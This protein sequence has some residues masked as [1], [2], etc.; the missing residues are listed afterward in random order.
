MLMGG[1]GDAAHIA[2]YVAIRIRV[3]VIDVLGLVLYAADLIRAVR[4]CTFVPV[5]CT[6]LAPVA[7]C[8]LMGGR[9]D[10]A[11]I[12]AYV[13]VRIRVIVIDVRGGILYAADLIRAVR[14][15]AFL[16]V[17]YRVMNPAA[18]IV[19]MVYGKFPLIILPE[20]F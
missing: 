17:V 20:T 7:V 8:M 10:A 13:A 4:I 3:V 6:V 11:H 2:A 9:G 15:C 12:A 5:V 14:I 18:V 1:R 19:L 16:P